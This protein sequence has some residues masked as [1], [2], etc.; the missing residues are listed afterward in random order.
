MSSGNSSNNSQENF[1]APISG[2]TFIYEF[3][4]FRLDAAHLMLYKS[5]QPVALQPKVVQTL[6]ALVERPGEV[7]SKNELMDRLWQDSFV[8]DANLS[9]NIYLLRKTFGDQIGERPLIET[10]WRRGY[11]FNGDIKRSTDVELLFATHTKTLVVTEEETVEDN[12]A[13]QDVASQV[14]MSNA[15]GRSKSF[16]TKTLIG[17]IAVVTGL[18]LVFGTLLLRSALTGPASTAKTAAAFSVIRMARLT[19]DLN[20]Q[21]QAISPDGKHLAYNLTENGK[22]SLWIKDILTG[23]GTMVRPPMDTVYYDLTFSPDGSYVYY[24]T[25]VKDRPNRTVFRVPSAGGEPQPIAYDVVS[26]LTFSPDQQ[27]IA[28]VR[29]RPGETS[30]VLA[31]SDGSGSERVLSSRSNTTGYETWA[32]SLSW[33]PDGLRIAICGVRIIDGRYTREL[34]E[35]NVADGSEQIIASPGWGYLDDVVWL[36]D[37]SGLIVRARET[38]ASPWQIWRVAY[39]SGEVS[40][41]T[42][43]LNDYDDPVLSADSRLLA[44]TKLV[45]NWNIWLT[46]AGDGG[47]ARQITFGS[48]ASDGSHGVAFTPDRK[49]VYTSPRDGNTDLWVMN[50]NG[51][52]QRQLTKNA[53]ELNRGPVVTRDGRF[54]VYDSSLSGTSQIWRMDADGGNPRQL[55][56]AGLGLNPFLSADGAWIYFTLVTDEDQVIAKIAIEGGEPV[57]IKPSALRYP[58]AG[59]LSPNGELM[60]VGFYDTGS[61][62]PWKYGVMSLKSGELLQVFEGPRVIGGWTEDSKSI[63]VVRE[64]NRSNLWLQPIDGSQARQLTSFEDGIVRSFAVSSDLKEIAIARG[65]PS[66]EAILITDLQFNEE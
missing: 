23:S 19:P 48:N 4:D 14:D 58:Y 30:I 57:I 50:T 8:E 12:D 54:I 22:H 36:S 35:V 39:P 1:T 41:V 10:F 28:F 33:S 26:P 61:K 43:D 27:R 47:Q 2:N 20:I 11:R 55:T 51:R 53:G 59:P 16:L 21:S 46:T 60:C 25:P 32:S 52:D 6:V 34:I 64:D 62:Q 13:E 3:A 40:R 56:H 29:L 5:G 7:V 17:T 42:N 15:V 63:I 45:G 18:I 38:H 9:Q 24:D 65:N 31:N 44:V 49:I 66:A 37:Q